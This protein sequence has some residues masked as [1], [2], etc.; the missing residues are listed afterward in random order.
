M[1]LYYQKKDFVLSS[2]KLYFQLNK[3]IEAKGGEYLWTLDKGVYGIFENDELIY[4]GETMRNFETRMREHN[5][6]MNDG[7]KENE[8]YQYIKEN[9]EDKRF[10]MRPLVEVDLRVNANRKLTQDE[11]YAIEL[12]FITCFMPRFNRAGVDVWYRLN[13]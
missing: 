3:D 4:V 9:F 12:G 13:K 2:G 8:M 11:V 5:Q 6:A 7:S 10:Y 1:Q